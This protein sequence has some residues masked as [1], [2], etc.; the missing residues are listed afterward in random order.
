VQAHLEVFKF[1]GF[2]LLGS[3]LSPLGAV[4]VFLFV[5]AVA[6]V[7]CF[8]EVEGALVLLFVRQNVFAT[9]LLRVSQVGPNLCVFIVE[10]A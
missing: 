7:G 9:F 1:F 6:V 8:S 5:F 10:L 3:L 4:L 2:L